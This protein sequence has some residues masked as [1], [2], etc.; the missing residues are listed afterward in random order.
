LAALAGAD[1]GAAQSAALRL[2][3]RGPGLTPEGDD[4]LVGACVALVAAGHGR[5][6]AA[7]LPSRLRKRTT[8]LSAT[9]LELAVVGAGA[10]PLRALLDLRSEQWRAALVRLESLGSSSGR[11]MALGAAALAASQASGSGPRRSV[12]R[13]RT[14]S[15]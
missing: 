8:A 7:L 13:S 11:A 15:G 10:E 9:L 14:A 2:V 4:L 1:L 12:S 5:R 6:A 3:G